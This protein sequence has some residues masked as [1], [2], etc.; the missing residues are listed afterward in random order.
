LPVAEFVFAGVFATV[1]VA[2]FATVLG[3][4]LTWL[5]PSA[6]IGQFA[7]EI[8]CAAPH[9]TDSRLDNFANRPNFR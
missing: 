9:C 6:G 3:V 5:V 8:S 7:R 1:F 2:V 4:L